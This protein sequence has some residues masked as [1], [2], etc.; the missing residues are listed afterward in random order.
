MLQTKKGFNDLSTTIKAFLV[1]PYSRLHAFV[2]GVALFLFEAAGCDIVLNRPE[3]TVSQFHLPQVYITCYLKAVPVASTVSSQN[4]ACSFIE[5]RYSHQS[6]FSFTIRK[7]M[8]SH[9]F[10]KCLLI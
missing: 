9:K 3:R 2:F 6:V 5:N 7:S 10:E 8:S 4:R 1:L